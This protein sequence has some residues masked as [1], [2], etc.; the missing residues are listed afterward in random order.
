MEYA[1]ECIESL[2]NQSYTNIEIILVD[3]G[4]TD[5]TSS[6]IDKW[7]QNDTRIK[8]IHQDNG[9]LS[10]A[11]NSGM[12]SATGD[13]IAFV[14][15]DD[16]VKKDYFKTLV[17]IMTSTNADMSGVGR[18]ENVPGE[19]LYR[20]FSTVDKVTVYSDYRDYVYDTYIDKGK[21]FFQS[22][23][24]VWGKLYRREIWEGID[25]PVGRNNEDSWVFPKVMARCDRIV[26]SPA[27]LYFY[28]KREGSIMSNVN[29]KLIR[30]KT[31]SWM[32]QIEWWRESED[33]LADK[34][35]ASCEKYI[36][37][38][39]FK[40]CKVMDSEYKK[41]IE[42]N[43]RIMVHHLILSKYSPLKTKIKYLTYARPQKVF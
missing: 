29:S 30:S 31:E 38:Y 23:I 3:D 22:S 8:V 36:C 6:I 5:D 1:G 17:D 19:N 11:R 43:Y 7:A 33:P 27:P 34:L 40:N 32:Q 28:R 14:D 15:G 21:R 16:S 9:G 2:V 12:R 37:H 39:I 26:I 24:V 10:V 35:L 20:Q 18:Y 41:S 25:F 42:E 4:S 13:C